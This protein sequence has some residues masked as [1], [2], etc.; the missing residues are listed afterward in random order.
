MRKRHIRL[1]ADIDDVGALRG[2]HGGTRDERLD[3]QRRRL[4]DLGEDAH[5]VAGKVGGPARLAEVE[6]QIDDLLRPALERHAVMALQLVEI[7]A[8]A[9]GHDNAVGVERPLQAIAHDRLGHQRGDL[10]ADVGDTPGSGRQAELGDRPVEAGL[11]EL[12]RQK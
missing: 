12:A 2:E 5:V 4:D 3:R 1:A 6:R 11:G 10:Y 9:P 7:H 8:G